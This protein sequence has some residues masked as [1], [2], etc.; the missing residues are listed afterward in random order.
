[1]PTRISNRTAATGGTKRTAP[2]TGPHIAEVAEQDCKKV[3]NP[4]FNRPFTNLEDAVDRLLPYHILDTEEEAETDLKE[5]EEAGS[6][7]ALTRWDAWQGYAIKRANDIEKTKWKLNDRID[8]AEKLA[9]ET[10]E[11]IRL[12]L[13]T[14]AA[15]EA[16]RDVEA[17]KRRR[18][19]ALA[20]RLEAEKKIKL[21]A[22]KMQQQLALQMQMQ[23][24]VNAQAVEAAAR[25]KAAQ[26]AKTAGAISNAVASAPAVAVP[27]AA[28]APVPAPAPIPAPPPAP[29]VKTEEDKRKDLLIMGKKLKS[30]K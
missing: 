5:A 28:P 29:V 18:A 27:V 10:S 23:M 25:E 16:E 1:M 12:A 11:T 30:K 14:Y 9:F 4:D 2:L 21:E 15:A 22:M 20:A 24:A 19:A 3:C 7:L 8:L 6:S 17:E 26:D 13:H